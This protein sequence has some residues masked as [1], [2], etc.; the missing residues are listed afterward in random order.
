MAC[1][2]M[3]SA[4]FSGG[5]RGS[6]CSHC[7]VE[8]HSL[9]P[10]FYFWF[11]VG[12]GGSDCSHC[13]V[14]LH[15]LQPNFHF[16]FWGWGGGSDCSHCKVELHWLQTAVPTSTSTFDSGGG[17]AGLQSHLELQILSQL[18]P[19]SFCSS[20]TEDISLTGKSNN[21][22]LAHKRNT[23]KV[24]R[25]AL[26]TSIQTWS[27]ETWSSKCSFSLIPTPPHCSHL[28]LMRVLYTYS[29]SV[30]E[31]QVQILMPVPSAVYP[32]VLNFATLLLGRWAIIFSYEI[33]VPE[34]CVQNRKIQ[35]ILW[36]VNV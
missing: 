28:N 13:K 32:Q 5:R 36:Q 1:H 34:F 11:W 14:E 30:S 33:S 29:I 16:W 35:R 15:S 25:T 31:G 20:I 6:D 8:L 23:R 22:N 17:G 24:R 27:S 9:Q 18:F 3:C 2:Y 7:K 21:N 4:C 10:D 19:L 26:G 12:G